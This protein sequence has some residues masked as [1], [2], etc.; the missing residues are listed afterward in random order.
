MSTHLQRRLDSG[1]LLLL[2]L[3]FI[4]A[5]IISNQLF[6]GWRIDFTENDLYTLSPG[7][8][9]ILGKI[10][11]PINLSFYYSDK[12]TENLPSLRSYANRVREMLEEVEDRADGMIKLRVIDL[13]SP[14]RV[15]R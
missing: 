12:A 5:V 10:E 8:Q 6:S 11:E 15:K 9:R 7:T 14:P 13:I 3:A 1:S 4:A 2:A